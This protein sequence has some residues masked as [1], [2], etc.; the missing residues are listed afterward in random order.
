[1]TKTHKFNSA[2]E[3]TQIMGALHTAGKVELWTLVPAFGRFTVRIKNRGVWQNLITCQL[4][5]LLAA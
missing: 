5:D 3:A 2:A 1:M 4:N